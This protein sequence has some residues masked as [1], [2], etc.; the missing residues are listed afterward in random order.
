MSDSDDGLHLHVLKREN[1]ALKVRVDELEQLA[2]RDTLTPVF[3]RRHFMTELGHSCWRTRRY[4]VEYGLLFIDVD[5]LKS[6]NDVHGHGTGDAVLI[7]IAKSLLA[8]VRRSDLVARMGGDE[9]AILLDNIP[10]TQ[11]SRTTDRI[12]KAVGRRRISFGGARV[13]PKIS[14]GFTAVEAGA[15]PVELLRRADRSMYAVK[16]AKAPAQSR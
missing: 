9:F 12:T 7:A 16:Q 3:N 1:R 4:G 8:S 11:I 10:A 13:L 6:V 5:N 2:V 15:K 14:V